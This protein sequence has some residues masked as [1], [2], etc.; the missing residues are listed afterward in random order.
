MAAQA[1]ASICTPAALTQP[2][3]QVLLAQFYQAPETWPSPP[4]HHAHARS[5]ALLCC[6]RAC[7]RT[8][9][10]AARVP[11]TW[12]GSATLPA[13]PGLA[14]GRAGVPRGAGST[15]TGV[16]DS[17]WQRLICS[18]HVRASEG[19]GF[20]LLS[21]RGLGAPHNPN[22]NFLDLGENQGIA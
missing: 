16:G 15:P 8:G 13:Q 21:L 18:M 10:E 12:N 7:R 9:E 4:F 20:I 2:L 14:G 19:L 6:T 22:W 5:T 1:C 3:L 11:S 17:P